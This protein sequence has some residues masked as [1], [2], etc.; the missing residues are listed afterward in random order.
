MEK[1][2][3][4]IDS[5]KTRVSFRSANLVFIRTIRFETSKQT[6]YGIKRTRARRSYADDD[7]NKNQGKYTW[8]RLLSALFRPLWNNNVAKQ[9][10]RTMRIIMGRSS[11]LSR[12]ITPA[13][14]Y[15]ANAFLRWKTAEKHEKRK[16]AKKQR[17]NA[18]KCLAGCDSSQRQ[19]ITSTYP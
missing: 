14:K 17:E 12:G 19:T 6:C 10:N 4:I 16:E 3:I 9:R 18:K 8:H 7:R 2:R 5:C 11:N 15:L 1:Y 13:I